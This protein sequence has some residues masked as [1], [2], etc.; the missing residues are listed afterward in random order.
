MTVMAGSGRSLNTK[1]TKYTKEG[2][3]A[4]KRG[5]TQ[6]DVG[7]RARRKAEGNTRSTQGGKRTA[8]RWDFSFVTSL[9]PPARAGVVSFVLRIVLL[10]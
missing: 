9:A 4:E 3:D 5:W 8:L 10:E 1:D 6:M 7:W 2:G